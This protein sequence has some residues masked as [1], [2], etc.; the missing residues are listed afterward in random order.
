MRPVVVLAGSE[1]PTELLGRVDLERRAYLRESAPEY[2]FALADPRPKVPIRRFGTVQLVRWGNT[3]GRSRALPRAALTRKDRVEAGDWARY[4]AVPV[5]VAATFWCAG[6][7]WLFVRE[8]I[9][10]V[11]VPDERGWAVCFVICEPATNYF[12]NMTGCDWMP[13]LINQRY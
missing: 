8:G 7:A 12:R 5:E 1:V 13:A 11:L 9:E 6:G 4:G 3:R 10:G 2:R